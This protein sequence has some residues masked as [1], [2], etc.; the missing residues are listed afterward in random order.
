MVVCVRACVHACVCVYVYVCVSPPRPSPFSQVD[1]YEHGDVL[2]QPADTDKFFSW[3]EAPKQ[4]E[5]QSA[6]QRW[7]QGEIKGKGGGLPPGPPTETGGE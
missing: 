2:F 1:V 6:Q 4:E 3:G 7:R 5:R